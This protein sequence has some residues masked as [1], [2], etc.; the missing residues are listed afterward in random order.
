MSVKKIGVLSSANGRF[1]AG[2]GIHLGKEGA[3]KVI[4]GG[5]LRAVDDGVGET[6]DI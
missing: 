4:E 3:G 1:R 2:W 6:E 5:V